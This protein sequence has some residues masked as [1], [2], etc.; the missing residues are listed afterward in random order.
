MLRKRE[1]ET[2]SARYTVFLLSFSAKDL[3]FS[4]VVSVCLFCAL[5]SFLHSFSSFFYPEAKEYAN[6]YSVRKYLRCHDD[7]D[8]C[9]FFRKSVAT[10][11][12][13]FIHHTITSSFHFVRTQLSEF[14]SL[15]ASAPTHNPHSI[16]VTVSVRHSD[17]TSNIWNTISPAVRRQKQEF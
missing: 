14:Y 1:T 15:N 5:S 12:E 13:T 2:Y 6:V 11:T 8:K 3:I 16:W 7:V 17:S 10:S 4:T 9:E